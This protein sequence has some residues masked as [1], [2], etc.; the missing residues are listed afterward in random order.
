MLQTTLLLMSQGTHTR[1]SSSISESFLNNALLPRGV[2]STTASV[3]GTATCVLL[4]LEDVINGP[5][6][7]GFLLR[8]KHLG[9][10]NLKSE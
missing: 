3:E 5:Q 4:P 8:L 2:T 10:S 7:V 1:I 6:A 9:Q